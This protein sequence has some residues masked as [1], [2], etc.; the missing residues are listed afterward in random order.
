MVDISVY[1]LCAFTHHVYGRTVWMR[2]VVPRKPGSGILIS[3]FPSC[4]L[5]NWY[6]RVGGI[7]KT[8][9]GYA[10]MEG[11]DFAVF[12]VTCGQSLT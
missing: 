12:R 9:D 4:I 11:K 5:K 1:W 8:L 2:E 7:G 10:I 3:A 6:L